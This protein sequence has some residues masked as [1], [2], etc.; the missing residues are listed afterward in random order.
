MSSEDTMYTE[1]L[2]EPG[3]RWGMTWPRILALLAL[4]VIA[5][6]AIL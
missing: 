6:W 4:L 5:Y 2:H 3:S 1:H